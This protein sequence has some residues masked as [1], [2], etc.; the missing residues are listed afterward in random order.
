M[1]RLT[2]LEAIANIKT[3]SVEATSTIKGGGA[4]GD[5]VLV[6]N[7]DGSREWRRKL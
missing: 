3:L 1:K 2:N 7:P 5:W 4:D 6:T